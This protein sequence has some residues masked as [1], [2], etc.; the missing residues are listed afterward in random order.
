MASARSIVLLS[1]PDPDPEYDEGTMRFRLYYEGPLRPTQRDPIN[2]QKDPLAPH[3]HDIRR[4]FH[5]QMKRLWTVNR[6]LR[7]HKLSRSSPR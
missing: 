1:G 2:D 3:K 5:D 7:E 6:F 4:A